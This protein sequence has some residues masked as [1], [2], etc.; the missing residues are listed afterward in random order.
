[1]NQI[2]KLKETLINSEQPVVLTGAGLGVSGAEKEFKKFI[3]TY[4]I[5]VVST[6]HGLGVFDGEHKLFLGI[7]GMH[8][9]YSA[10]MAIHEA[11]LENS[12]N[13]LMNILHI[14]RDTVQ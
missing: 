13:L 4:Q 2:N 14:K 11:D 5:P 7:A 12:I 8:G 6:L 1:M 10:N 9:T 3:D